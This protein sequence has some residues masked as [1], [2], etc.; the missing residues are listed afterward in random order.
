M[1]KVEGGNNTDDSKSRG[2]LSKGEDTD[3]RLSGSPSV[4]KDG[5]M[6]VEYI[7]KTTNPNKRPSAI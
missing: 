6:M 3:D 1:K 4:S 2:Y 7:K 5:K